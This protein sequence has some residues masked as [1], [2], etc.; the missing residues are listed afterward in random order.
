[1][2]RLSIPIAEWHGSPCW[3]NSLHKA[4]SGDS[5]SPLLRKELSV[6]LLAPNTELY[7]LTIQS[8]MLMVA[9]MISFKTKRMCKQIAEFYAT[10]D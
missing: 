8:H 4:I 3:F 6:Y 2:M 5:E 1:M 10:N 7:I 9:A